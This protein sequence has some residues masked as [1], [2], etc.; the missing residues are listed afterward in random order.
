[1]NRH[2]GAFPL[3]RQKTSQSFSKLKGFHMINPR[4]KLIPIAET[5]LAA[6]PVWHTPSLSPDQKEK[7]R[8]FIRPVFEVHF[9]ERQPHFDGSVWICPQAAKTHLLKIG[10]S[11]GN[12]KA[13]SARQ[14]LLEI[15]YCP[16]DDV[17][18]I[19]LLDVSNRQFYGPFPGWPEVR[20]V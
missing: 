2:S 5:I 20:L 18:W 1:M 14:E 8:K 17:Y 10:A 16:L 6:Y 12:F 15:L 11:R 19:A 3:C 7:V 9:R 4:R 13:G